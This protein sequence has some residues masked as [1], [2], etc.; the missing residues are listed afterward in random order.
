MAKIDAET[1]DWR[2]K[3]HAVRSWSEIEEAA[4]KKTLDDVV[5]RSKADS[6]CLGP[7]PIPMHC[8]NPKSP[9]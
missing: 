8:P 1:L 9:P 3:R 7:S 5:A 2:W 4:A 6:D